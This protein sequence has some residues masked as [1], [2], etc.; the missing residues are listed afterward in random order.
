MDKYRLLLGVLFVTMSWSC[1]QTYAQNVTPNSTSPLPNGTMTGAN[2]TM[3]GA[4]STL[5]GG[6]ATTPGTN[7]T[8]QGASNLTT[9][10]VTTPT[11]APLAPNTSV[12]TLPTTV[13]RTE[14]G[15]TQLCAAEPSSCDPSTGSSCFFL[16]A[17]KKDGNNFEFALSGESDGY[18][19]A[20]VLSP[21]NNKEVTYICANDNNVVKFFGAILESGQLTMTN[22]S[23]NSVKG[24]VNGKKIQC[25]FLATVP[26]TR[27]PAAKRARRATDVTL[28]VSTGAYNA[29]SG[30]LGTPTTAVRAAV[31][32][33]ANSNATVVNEIANS[34]NTSTTPAPG[35]NVT[36]PGA[37]AT[38]PG[39]NNLTTPAVT[40]P[41]PAPLAPNTSVD[42]LATTVN[43]TECGTTQ[44]CA[45]EPSSCD[46]A[47][48]S[49]CFFL[50]AQKKD[51]NNFEFAL[52]GESDGYIAAS[53]LSPFNNKEVTYICANNKDVVKFFGA[54]L[55][56]GKLNITNVSATSVKGK[57]NGKKI[58]CRFLATVPDTRFP[59]AKRARRATDV[60]LSVSNGTYNATSD[61]LGPPVRAIIAVVADLANPNTT[62]NNTITNSTNTTTA[63]TTASTTTVGSLQT[64]INRNGCGTDKLC[65]SEPSSCN[66]ADGGTCS[67]LSAKLKSGQ[68]Y[69]FE[70]SGLSDGY[71]ASAVSSDSTAGNGDSTYVCANNNGVVKFI[72]A[73]YNSNS[74][75]ETALNVTSGSTYG[76][77]NG[78]HIQCTFE[79]TLPDTTT[80]AATYSMIIINGTY[81]A[82]TNAFGIPLVLL[83]TNLVNLSDP[84]AN[85]TNL[86]SGVAPHY[87]PLMQALL[88][89]I[90]ILVLP[91]FGH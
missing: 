43:R 55:E 47:T 26:D 63:S 65:A 49:S 9:P 91:I 34:T 3:T 2:G 22:V 74:L 15:T 16:G 53:V 45:A 87:H 35:A 38:T 89:T 27:I 84:S 83:R 13:S 28:S 75:T 10:A 88:V 51:G 7:G 24:K 70:L 37:N 81:D 39:A 66:P 80:R 6:N 12:E 59:L 32:D 61:N 68:I 21:F 79:A 52:S 50:G 56:N 78:K 85:T 36:T 73:T 86:V 77:I 46:P 1:M 18:I 54:I 30:T 11:P 72:T 20:S 8:G 17:Q 60:T 64:D 90:A 40:T 44:L 71:I 5:P 4:N 76:K 57:V 69:S 58:Q 23:A 14:C 31:A 67:F 41:T 25:T 19:A 48:G 29:S 33:L 62:V 82:T 42:T